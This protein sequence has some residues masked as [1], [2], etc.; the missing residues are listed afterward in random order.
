MLGHYLNFILRSILYHSTWSLH[1]KPLNF[2][3]L[4]LIALVSLK[5]KVDMPKACLSE[6][7]L[8]LCACTEGH[9]TH[10][11]PGIFSF[12]AVWHPNLD[13]ETPQKQHCR[14]QYNSLPTFAVFFSLYTSQ[15]FLGSLTIA[16]GW[17]FC[18]DEWFKSLCDSLHSTEALWLYSHGIIF[19][20]AASSLSPLKSLFNRLEMFRTKVVCTYSIDKLLLV[21]AE[22]ALCNLVPS[23]RPKR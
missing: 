18:H 19:L 13:M 8:I 1:S 23:S 7:S 3:T 22:V 16:L 12:A 20:R 17:D 2:F 6:N 4:V 14:Q 5:H 9:R 10:H 21:L 11:S 15:N